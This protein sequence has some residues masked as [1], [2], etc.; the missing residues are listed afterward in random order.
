MPPTAIPRE[1]I[2]ASC[3]FC[4]KPDT[5]VQ[6]LVAGPGVYICDE[7]ISLSATLVEGAARTTPEESSRRQSQYY[8]RP[9]DDILAMLPALLRSAD[10]V[11]R[12]LT[13]WVSR[14]RGRG[15]SWQTIADAAG[16]DAET[17]RRRFE[18]ALQE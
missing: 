3:S 2:I 17:A 6:R 8:D 16:L 10:R 7:C 4:A 13:G 5:A 15:A 18:T 12:E 1:D 9:T 14:L 11:E